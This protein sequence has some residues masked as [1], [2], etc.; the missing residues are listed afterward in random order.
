MGYLPPGIPK[1][2]EG[3]T[4][5]APGF[6]WGLKRAGEVIVNCYLSVLTYYTAATIHFFTVRRRM[7]K[8]DGLGLRVGQ[9]FP[10]K[11]LDDD[12]GRHRN[13]RDIESDN[14]RME[15]GDVFGG[16][17]E[18]GRFAL[19]RQ[20]KFNKAGHR[21]GGVRNEELFRPVWNLENVGKT[22]HLL[23]GGRDAEKKGRFLL[24]RRFTINS[25]RKMLNQ[26]WDVVWNA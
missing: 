8:H 16:V 10:A 1:E 7:D 13:L 25:L 9:D 19:R 18:N 15:L 24:T 17:C 23:R 20:L 2:T 22:T 11:S 5:N 21:Q 14:G 4:D 3:V 6:M 26:C 12:G